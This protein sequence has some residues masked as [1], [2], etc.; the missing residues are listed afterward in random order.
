MKPY[1][2]N[3]KNAQTCRSG[4]C[5]YHKGRKDHNRRA[6]K[7]SRRRAKQEILTLTP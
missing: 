1:D 7:A 5:G 3:R 2:P 4:C 6:R